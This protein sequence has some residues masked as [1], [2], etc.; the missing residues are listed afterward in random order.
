[1]Q[2]GASSLGFA[3]L[4]GV[5]GKE[6]RFEIELSAGAW[7]VVRHAWDPEAGLD[8]AAVL[9][10]DL[11]GRRHAVCLYDTRTASRSGTAIAVV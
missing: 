6:Q 5:A 8:W 10:V 11:D 3:P 2:E 4:S 7:I 9:T 1:M